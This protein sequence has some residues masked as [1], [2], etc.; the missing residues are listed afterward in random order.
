MTATAKKRLPD[1]RLVG[2][3]LTLFSAV[4]LADSWA[5]RALGPWAYYTLPTAVF[6]ASGAIATLGTHRA[7]LA[8]LLLAALAAT[9]TALSIALA[10]HFFLQSRWFTFGLFQHGDAFDFLSST[11]PIL[12]DG[13]YETARGRVFS[14]VMYTGLL[15]ATDFD[16]RL[17]QMATAA[18]AAFAVIAGAFA[19]GGIYGPLGA[20]STTWILFDFA[21][22]HIGGITTEIPG[23]ALGTAGAVL[24]LL[25]SRNRS[26]AAFLL[27]VLLLSVGMAVRI[28][29]VFLLFGL[30][31][32][33]FLH[34]GRSVLRRVLTAATALAICIG[35]FAANDRLAA[36]VSPTGGG[37]FVNAVNSWYAVLVEGQLLLDRRDEASVVPEARWTQIF[38]DHPEILTRP[39]AERPGLQFRIFLT[40]VA[41]D[42]AALAAGMVQEIAR[43]LGLMR[44]FQFIEVKPLRML[45]ALLTFIGI[46]R[47]LW[48]MTRARDPLHDLLGGGAIALI[49]SQPFLYGGETR[50]PAP[51]V[52]FLATLAVVGL[53]TL[54]A[55]RDGA[56]SAHRKICAQGNNAIAAAFALI[57]AVSIASAFAWGMGVRGAGISVPSDVDCAPE[58]RRATILANAGIP[59]ATSSD[60][61]S[62]RRTLAFHR[63]FE[64]R[65]FP[66]VSAGF[67]VAIPDAALWDAIADSVPR[68][69][70]IGYAVDP[71]AR[72]LMPTVLDFTGAE[73]GFV[74]ACL[75]FDTGIWR[76]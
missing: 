44:L 31:L 6:L 66:L 17:V 50:T 64:D 30:P 25:S 21:H 4:L 43:Y 60:V 69:A 39:A 32:W 27:G 16:L 33:A 3:V 61:D 8:L 23:F 71:E 28:G 74:G 14:N 47:C 55:M 5:V 42:P 22:E 75:R 76:R 38:E 18:T 40:E 35:V 62:L 48:G 24:I 68:P 10:H 67:P 56:P 52:L 36:T 51:T 73:Q 41:A 53:T 11:V 15:A 12:I 57:A 72:L 34:I 49:L 54:L 65:R 37:S 70:R 2:V 1:I 26:A 7:S 59:L 29:A 13:T 63:D 19:I 20:A 9:A 45:A 46:A 58:E